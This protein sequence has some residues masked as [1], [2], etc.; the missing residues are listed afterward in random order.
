[1]VFYWVCLYKAPESHCFLAKDH[2]SF[3]CSLPKSHHST[4]N[5]YTRDYPQSYWDTHNDIAH[6]DGENPHSFC[7]Y[8]HEISPAVRLSSQKFLR[9]LQGALRH[10]HALLCACGAHQEPRAA[11]AESRESRITWAVRCQGVPFYVE[12][13]IHCCDEKD[14][15]RMFRLEN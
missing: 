12:L 11:Q 1:M 6:I 10:V 15:S 8:F 13:I 4:C 3:R 7:P 9:F 5:T 14:Y 2:P